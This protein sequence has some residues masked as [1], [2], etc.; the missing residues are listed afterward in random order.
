MTLGMHCLNMEKTMEALLCGCIL[1]TQAGDIGK[2]G[3]VPLKGIVF[4]GE[5][6]FS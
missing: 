2:S 3:D 4:F 1:A 5:H 6:M